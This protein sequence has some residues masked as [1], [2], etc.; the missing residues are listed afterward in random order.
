MRSLQDQIAGKCIHFTGTINKKC[1]K[2]ILYDTV[3]DK[4]VRPF[5]LPCLA[6]Q[7]MNGGECSHC[8][9]PSPEE[10]E[11][12]IQEIESMTQETL[13]GFGTVRAHYEKTKEK[14]GK[15]PCSACSGS[16]HYEVHGNGHI[17]AKCDGCGI[18]WIE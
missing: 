1:K 2:D 13:E 15:V 8:E 18:G 5:T 14:V 9:F 17:W 7:G 3:R 12:R 11:K 6:H 4:T 10:V 16:L